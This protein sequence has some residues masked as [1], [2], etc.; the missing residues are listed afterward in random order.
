[1]TSRKE[2][3]ALVLLLALGAPGWPA[4]LPATDLHGDPLPEG[5][6]A[7]LGA[8]VRLQH[9]QVSQ[10][11]FAADG[12]SLYSLGADFTIRRWVVRTGRELRRVY[13]VDEGWSL[14]GLLSLS[15]DGK[16]LA[17]GGRGNEIYLFDTATLAIRRRLKGES[18]WTATQPTFS[19]DGKQLAANSGNI[20]VI[21]WDLATGRL[22]PPRLE[23]GAGTC[24]GW[25][26]DGKVLWCDYY[27]WD[28]ATGKRSSWWRRDV[29][30]RVMAPNGRTQATGHKDHTIRLWDPAMTKERRCL[31]GH[32]DE[33]AVLAFS[34][35][36]KLLASGCWSHPASGADTTVR[37]WEAATGKPLH[38]LAGHRGRI[39]SLSF[40]PD[41]KTL[42]S[43]AEDDRI[44]LWDI[45][46]GKPL[47]PDKP[48]ERIALVA[49]SPD[50]RALATAGE[51]PVRLWDAGSGR[52]RAALPA[53]SRSSHALAYSPD[54]KRLATA[55]ADG[56]VRL[57]DLAA[58]REVRR[59]GKA[60]VVRSC[61][62]FAADGRLAAGEPDV[63]VWDPSTGK[64]LTRFGEKSDPLTCLA[65]SPD[66]KLLAA[67]DNRHTVTLWDV[68]SGRV[69][70]QSRWQDR[71]DPRGI[72]AVSFSPDGTT[73]AL[74]SGP[75]AA[76]LLLWEVRTGK[77]LRSFVGA[78]DSDVV[79]FSPDGRMLASG[80]SGPWG[81]KVRLLEVETGRERLHFRANPGAVRCVSFA[82]DGRRLA[83]THEDGTALVWQ[84]WPTTHR[85]KKPAAL[86]AGQLRTL[87]AD[88]ESPDA[89]RSWRAMQ[90]LVGS[91]ETAV[92]FLGEQVRSLPALYRRVTRLVADLD[93]KRFAV[94]QRATAELQRMGRL[95]EASLRHALEGRPSLEARRRMEAV[96]TEI[97]KRSGEVTHPARLSGL[98]AVEALEHI[99]NEEARRTLR[100]LAEAAGD[101]EI[102]REA[103]ASLR[104]QTAR[105]KP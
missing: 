21:R 48:F 33:V 10:V 80:S 99:G 11:L 66:G 68:A 100:S 43:A 34:P 44:L 60:G 6:V 19:P 64:R 28:L 12:K 8:P 89:A 74:A 41:G 69:V 31:R 75:G 102:A 52:Q 4:P 35:D 49:F 22:I 13:G 65:F 96:L 87:W 42:A 15:P 14:G 9:L 57:W 104:R 38:T 86:S 45:R 24:L 40:S 17:T 36:S 53:S 7:R 79:V 16:L 84:V 23:G 103:K 90:T 72:R 82:P 51:G 47:H 77:T 83:T 18:G 91:P 46:S 95:A 54:G 59:L 81:D 78:A 32:K 56:G 37:L 70:R 93:A 2:L 105:R 88:L 50:G 58:G 20:H 25:S 71:N 67:G 1:M 101:S 27:R 76:G 3:G 30:S 98:R 85:G 61:L 94:R 26:S 29:T 39:H 97:E 92:P 63:C 55:A 5:A 73:L 62:A